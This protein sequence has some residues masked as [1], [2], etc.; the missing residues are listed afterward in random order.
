MTHEE[1]DVMSLW[2]SYDVDLRLNIYKHINTFLD[3]TPQPVIAGVLQFNK[4][5]MMHHVMTEGKGHFNPQM[6]KNIIDYFFGVDKSPI[7]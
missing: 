4:D 1:M 6:V 5:D 7:K 3:D 2:Y